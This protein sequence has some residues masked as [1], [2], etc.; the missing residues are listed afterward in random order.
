MKVVKDGWRVV[1]GLYED[2]LLESLA[3][4]CAVKDILDVEATG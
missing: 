2:G 1:C 3:C 4:N